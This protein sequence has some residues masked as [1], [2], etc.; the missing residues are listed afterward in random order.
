MGSCVDAWYCRLATTAAVRRGWSVLRLNTR[1]ADR[2]GASIT[3]AGLS[4][5]IHAA[6]ASRALSG[7]RTLYLLGYSLGG[8][9]V[10]TAATEAELDPRVRAVVT[11]CAPMLL[12]EGAAHIDHPANSFYRR[13]LLTGLREVYEPAWQRRTVPTPWETLK[14]ADTLRAY[15]ALAV[16]PTFGFPDVDTYYATQSVGPKLGELRVPAVIV[17]AVDDPMVPF[18]Q[19]TRAM[20][21]ANERARL[22][23]LR[24]GGH[25]A[26][27]AA[28]SSLA[29]PGDLATRMLE[30]VSAL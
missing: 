28:G 15:D 5:D 20:L 11:L 14:K 6:L 25:V 9:Q 24:H 23:P 4:A 22:V 21:H 1:G 13:H 17:H 29:G 12:H 2:S 27:I 19:V 8:H 7:F 26:G 18:E 3:H 30:A 10:L 16:V